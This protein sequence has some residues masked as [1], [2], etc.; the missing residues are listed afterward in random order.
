MRLRAYFKFTNFVKKTLK[1]KRYDRLIV[2]SPL[3]AILLV[4]LLEKEYKRKY[5]LD[6][7]D[8]SVEQKFCFKRLFLKALQNSFANVISSP[9]FKKYLPSGFN[10]IL[11]HNFNIDVVKKALETNSEIDTNPPI[12][13]ILTIG[14]IRDYESN[15]QVIESLANKAG[16]TVRFVGKGPSAESLEFYA[17]S[18]N[19]SN[20]S[21]EGFYPKEKEKEYVE[22]ATFLNIFYPRKA[23]HDTALS[24]RF[25]NSLI[26]KKPMITTA[27]TI[28]GDYAA[29]F[30]V[31]IAL[32][33]CK[34]LPTELKSFL[35][36]VDSH[37]YQKL[38]NALLS[39][40]VL[41][42]EKWESV[43][44]SFIG[45]YCSKQK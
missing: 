19:A 21:F 32:S 9:G 27:D 3:T 15:S 1:A 4:P 20:I 44:M 12:I 13:D 37:Q 25:Y 7:R 29:K 6:Y 2:F 33:D 30:K 24:N 26:Y 38:C 10:Y 45:E 36:N 22:K 43:V 5:I 23:S 39:E 14:G 34:N 28:Q 35:S 40:F 11:S 16:F 42:Y 41:D 18:L 31:G 17:K 8:L